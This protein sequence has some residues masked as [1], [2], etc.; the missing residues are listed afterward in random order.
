MSDVLFLGRSFFGVTLIDDFEL[1]V[2]RLYFVNRDSLSSVP[3]GES[4]ICSGSVVFIS[5]V[6]SYLLISTVIGA[7]AFISMGTSV[8]L[9]HIVLG[10]VNFSLV[11]ELVFN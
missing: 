4:L 10:I 5:M 9:M 3:R 11:L 7:L 1:L 2:D 6:T 8:I